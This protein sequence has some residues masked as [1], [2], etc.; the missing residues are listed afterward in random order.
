M[1][2]VPSV[3]LGK[4]FVDCLLAFA[5]SFRLSAKPG[6]LVVSIHGVTN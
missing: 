3:T 2:P 1:G 4:A 5:E 6:F